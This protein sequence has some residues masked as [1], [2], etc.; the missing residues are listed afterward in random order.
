MREGKPS[1]TAMFVAAYRGRASAASAPLFKDPWAA[2]L[3]GEEGLR[4]AEAYDRI[5]P[6]AELY[7]AVRTAYLDAQIER[8]AR[9]SGEAAQ[10]V[11]LGAGLDTRPARLAAPGRR[12]FEVDHPN[13]QAEKLRRLAA[14]PGY[15]VDAATFVGC[16]FERDDFLDKLVASGFQASEPALF[17]WEGV[18]YYLT[19]EAVR[20]T[21]RRI[22]AGASERAVVMFDF[23]EKRAVEGSAREVDRAI[24]ASF[25]EVGEP[26]RF[27]CNNMIPILFEAGYRH[28]R[29][30]SFDEVCL[31]LTGT[32]E[33]SRM[34]RFQ[35]LALASRSGAVEP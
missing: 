14:L 10:V 16:D 34:F 27:G 6:A 30:S 8:L 13:T 4:L 9:P 19:E 24:R 29:V 3:G 1:N 26:L 17:L 20:A 31:H 12:Y 21:L 28:V 18:V 11:I 22:A 2:S 23:I 32:Y 35:H 15:P 25:E 33:R 5:H 7:F